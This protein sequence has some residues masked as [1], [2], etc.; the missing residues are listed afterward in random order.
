VPITA[1]YGTWRSPISADLVFGQTVALGNVATFDGALYWVERGAE[2][3]PTL[4]RWR[5]GAVRDLTPGFQVGTAI[6]EYGGMPYVVAGNRILASSRVN[7]RLYR[8]PQPG[9]RAPWSRVDNVRYADG[10][11]DRAGQRV[12]LVRE[13]LRGEGYP[14]ASIVSI[15]L[16]RPQ[17]EAVLLSGEGP[18]GRADFYAAPR[19]SADGARI[20]WMSWALPH[21]PWDASALYVAGLEKSGAIARIVHVAGGASVSVLQPEW[22]PDGALYFLSDASGWWNLH[23]WDGRRSTPVT[24]E[25]AEAGGPLWE[26]GASY[27]A[28]LRGG[29]IACAFCRDGIWQM[30]VIA[31]GRWRALRMPF[32]EIAQVCAL[33]DDIFCLA[34]GPDRPRAIVRINWRSARHS[35][36]RASATVTPELLPFVSLPQSMTFRVG[37][38][39]RTHGFYYAPRN[40]DYEPPE[41]AR[42]PLIVNC[43]GGPTGATTTTLKPGVQFWTSRGFAYL[44]LNYTGST[45]Y[46]RRYRDALRRKWGVVDVRDSVAAALALVR[47]RKA[48]RDALIIR[49]GSAGGYT[50]L[51]ALAF[52]P[53]VFSAGAS[54]FGIGDLEAL[55]RETHKFESGYNEWLVGSLATQRKRSPL[56]AV[57]RI[58]APV[59]FFQGEEDRV[60]PPNQS[61]AM[62]HALRAKGMP[63]G[64]LLFAGEGHGFRVPLNNVRTLEAELAFYGSTVLRAGPV[65]VEILARPE[66]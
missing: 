49:G 42:P 27:Y 43:H 9:A 19:P 30:G 31:D 48:T 4:M 58:R 36:I 41:R 6:H 5:A 34:G 55:A 14:K 54:H 59:I 50:T 22:G 25:R 7:S 64:L 47:Q 8:F 38:S 3:R 26:L 56:H 52:K 63:F 66:S 24:K 35:V 17:D 20:A 57:R 11:F 62:A 1:A 65:L 18:G 23:R 29:R 28:F 10:R 12:L 40:P 46:G 61:L 33:G 53:G 32:E 44:D 39:Q 51:A 37:K 16:A 13:D 15:P 45:G 21:M 60:V 2:N